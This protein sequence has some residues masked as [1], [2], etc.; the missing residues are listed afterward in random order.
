MEDVL[1]TAITDALVELGFG[2]VAFS[3]EH[4]ENLAFGDYACNAAMVV[5][6]TAGKAPREVAAELM[7]ALEGQIEYV[8]KIEIAG[9]GFLN[10]TFSRDFFTQEIFRANADAQMWGRNDSWQGKKVFVEY[11]DPNPFKEFHIGH[12]FTNTV[13][14]SI[15]RLF[16]MGGADVKRLNY[17]GDVGLHVAHALFGMQALG[18]VASSDFSARDL[19]KAYAHGA[20]A[21]KNEDPGAKEAIRAINKKT[22]D[23]SDAEINALYDKGR[24]VSLAYF[25]EIYKILDTQFDAY[26]FESECAPIGKE[27]VLLNPSVFVESDGARVFK[28]EEH[29]LHTRVFLNKE[30]LPTYEAKELALAE[31]KEQRLGVCDHSITSTSNEITEYFKVLKKALSFI[32]PDYAEKLEHIGHGTVRLTTGKMSS[33]TGDVISAVDFIEEVKDA[34]KAKVREGTHVEDITDA[35][36]EEIAIGAI[37][38][39]TLKSNILQDST[40]DKDQALSFE[41][42]SGPYLQYTHA[43]ICSVL[44][45]ASE[46]GVVPGGSVVPE[47]SYT[48][49]RMLYR[50]P[51]VVQKALEER[52]PHFVATY[53][54]EL[55]SMFNTF[56]AHE[57]I[58]DTSDSFAPYKVVVATAVAH[59]LKNGLWVL[60]IK[61]P[62]SM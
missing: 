44:A 6:K 15:A 12:V 61:A 24:A 47:T 21:Y 60:G 58:A 18:I 1:K 40:F 16:M 59:T 28:G 26:F 9:P 52:A 11:T 43:R 48:L 19:G 14:E 57:K 45:K 27:L 25:E 31:L 22:Y 56:Y 55:A 32:N 8:E 39:A 53:L 10:F 41:G 62:T 5:A 17:Q 2:E 29:G 36:A 49:E 20:T 3:L 34:V 35:L 13:G 54:T 42:N 33:R 30:G 37:K 51:E 7:A 23:R 38:F 46:V 4:P 50:F